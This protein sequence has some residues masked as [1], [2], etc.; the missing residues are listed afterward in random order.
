MARLV[1]RPSTSRPT[2]RRCSS[3]SPVRATRRRVLASY[4]RDRRVR[5]GAAG[6]RG[7]RR[8]SRPTAS[9]RCRSVRARDPQRWLSIRPEPAT[10]ASSRRADL[11]SR[12]DPLSARRQAVVTTANEPGHGSRIYRAWI[13]P[14]GSRARCLPR[15]IARPREGSRRTDEDR[16]DRPRS[17]GVPVPAGGGRADRDRRLDQDEVVGWMDARTG[18]ALRLSAPG[19]P[20]TALSS[21]VWR[22]EAG[23]LRRE[24]MPADGAGVVDIAPVFETPDGNVLRLRLPANALG[25]LS[26][27]RAEVDRLNPLASMTC[28]PE[29]SSVPTRSSRRSAPAAW[30]RCTGRRIRA[31]GA[32]WRSRFCRRPSR[33]IPDRLKRF[34]QEARAAGVLNHPNIT[35][36]Y[37]IGTH[38]GAPYIVTELLE[39]ET[40]RAR[41]L[42]GRAAG[43]QG[44]RLRGPDREGPGGGA[45]EGDRPPGPQA[46]EP[47]PDEGRAGQ[48]PRLRS[49]EARR[50]RRTGAAR[51]TSRRCRGRSP[52]SCSA[53]WATCRRSR[54]AGRP[55]TTRRD[56][57]SFG[58]ILYEMLAGQRAFRG[59][60]AADTITAILTEGA[61][62]SRADEQGDPSRAGSDR[63]ALPGEEPGGALRVGPRRRVRSGCS[64]GHLGDVVGRALRS[65][66]GGAS[67]RGAPLAR[68]SPRGAAGRGDREPVRVQGRQEGRLRAAAY[69]SPDHVLA[70]RGRQRALRSGRADDR[71]L[72]WLGGQALRGLHQ[73]PGEPRV[74][75][76]RPR[77]GRG[78]VDLQVRRARGAPSTGIPY[79]HSSER[80]VWRAS[81]SR[82][83]R[84]GTSSTTSSTPTGAPTARRWPS[85]AT[86]GSRTA[87][88][89]RSARSSSRRPDGSAN[90]AS[91][92]RATESRSSIT[93]SRTT[94]AAGS[95][96]STRGQEDEPDADLRHRPGA[97]LD[98]RRRRDLVHGR[99]GGLQPRR[100]CGDEERQ[101]PPGRARARDQ[102][103]S[104]HLQGR[105][106]PDDQRERAARRSRA[107]P[108]R[109]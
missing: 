30:E 42:D 66:R 47:V 75:A 103:D 64:V 53:R 56:L 92:P 12:A 4:P 60:T 107:R 100:P 79:T 55:P 37:D 19:H 102:H 95:R 3:R 6:G 57:F 23:R 14:G 74:A 48:D 31:S 26:R 63:P 8:L 81:R 44:A 52:A 51:P 9:G 22:P 88:S 93:R 94:T 54:C 73:P 20:G 76:L 70:R 25:S 5:P 106:R 1:R 28:P 7:Q 33:R 21:R 91:R 13:S 101:D 24:V 50:P 43:A 49:G 46:R 97:R 2:A 36:V 58:T 40:L 29:P 27:R 10:S 39:G 17:Q 80:G 34:E 35:A 38:D 65:A 99:R 78:A 62:G 59:D 82:A 86:S 68:A 16:G 96:S 90:P 45:R 89:I 84:R 108:G 61:A 41:L 71:L 77:R 67:V 98:S 109:G 85:S 83:A 87:S 15:G 11:G 104:R 105:T 69:V 72:G 32:T 18:S